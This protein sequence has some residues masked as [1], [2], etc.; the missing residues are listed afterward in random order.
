MDA[1]RRG[2]FLWVT[3]PRNFDGQ[4]LLLAAQQEGVRYS[5]GE[6][7]HSNADGRHTLRLTYSTATTQ[8]IETGIEILGRLIRQNWPGLSDSPPRKT[9]E[10]MPIV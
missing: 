3:L 9:A 6:L 2:L 8:Q 7:F 1:R 5:S 10:P 4:Q